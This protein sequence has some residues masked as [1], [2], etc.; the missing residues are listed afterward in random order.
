MV[1][2]IRI[3]RSRLLGKDHWGGALPST[4]T[5]P[6]P[7]FQV[8]TVE[9]LDGAITQV[10]GRPFGKSR[11]RPVVSQAGEGSLLPTVVGSPDTERSWRGGKGRGYH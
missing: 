3:K 9:Q 11:G 7:S 1:E 4:W 10:P 8:L 2:K 5:P 6:P